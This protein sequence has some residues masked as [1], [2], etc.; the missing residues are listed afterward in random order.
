MIGKI[1]KSLYAQGMYAVKTGYS[2]SFS[3]SIGNLDILYG[4]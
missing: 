4:G 2:E 1:G 3:S